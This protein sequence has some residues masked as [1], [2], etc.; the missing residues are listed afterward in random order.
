MG[1]L[2]INASNE[3]YIYCRR[4]NTLQRPTNNCH[5]FATTVLHCGAMAAIESP[6]IYSLTAGEI[7]FVRTLAA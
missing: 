4:A 7:T 2:Q 6:F 5:N 3:V 1:L